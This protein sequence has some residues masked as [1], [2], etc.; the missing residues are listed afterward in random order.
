MW[1]MLGIGMP[2]AHSV[3]HYDSSSGLCVRIAEWEKCK[4]GM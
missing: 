3:R 1:V 4:V 2:S